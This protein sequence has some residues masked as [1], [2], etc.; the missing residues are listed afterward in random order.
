MTRFAPRHL[1][2]CALAMAGL[3]GALP[4]SAAAVLVNYTFDFHPP[5]PIAMT[6]ISAT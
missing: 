2:V 1:F 4:A 6:P 5:T 3:L